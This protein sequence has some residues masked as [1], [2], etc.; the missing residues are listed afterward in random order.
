M[1]LK[2]NDIVIYN[3]DIARTPYLVHSVNENSVSLGLEDY[4]DVEQDWNTPIED[5]TKLSGEELKEARKQINYIL[6]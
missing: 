1:R 6:S 5:V 2:P 4:P 3:D